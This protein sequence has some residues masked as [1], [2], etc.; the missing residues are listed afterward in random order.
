MNV[1]R[2]HDTESEAP[3]AAISSARDRPPAVDCSHVAAELTTALGVENVRAGA[4]ASRYTT[5]RVGGA[6]EL[7]CMVHSVE[8]LCKAVRIVRA[9]GLPWLVL[10]RGSNVLIDDAGFAGVMII[11][12]AD[13]LSIDGT[14]V[15]AESGVL[16]SVLARRTVA[17]GLVGLAWCHDIPGTVGGAVVNNA[18]ANGGSMAD[19]VRAAR[20]L[21]L[22]GTICRIDTADLDFG[23]RHSALRA[24]AAVPAGGRSVVLDVWFT[25]SDGDTFD[26]T[27]EMHVQ[28]ARRKATQPGGASAGSV[29]KNPPGD[30]AGRLI[31]AA[32]LKGLRAGDAAVSQLHGNFIVTGPRACAGDVL[33]LIGRMRQCV[34]DEFGVDLQPEVQSVSRDG[35][36]GPP[37]GV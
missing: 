2:R 18:G 10:G 17:S 34:R 24:E 30:S 4:P 21:T 29:F 32:G 14:D 37:G 12:R 31:D 28:R 35:C 27:K 11:N 8:A 23:Y 6:A 1:L 36:I 16:L 3:A 5:W 9:A 26:I 25:L 20:L 22:D 19:V 15:R 33:E 7:L 13:G